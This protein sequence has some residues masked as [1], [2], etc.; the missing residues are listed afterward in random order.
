[1]AAVGN[2]KATQPV[3]VPALG[4]RYKQTRERAEILFGHRNGSYPLPDPRVSLFQT[5]V[6][7]IPS[8]QPGKTPVPEP[9]GSDETRL[10]EA[11]A[12]LKG[13]GGFLTTE[14]GTYLTVGTNRYREGDS[15]P[16][17]VRSGTVEL[18]IVRISGNSATVA[19]NQTEAVL[20]F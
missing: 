3:T 13:G 6:E 18:R 4:P 11:L 1:M 7:A 17:S 10:A 20:R 5:P 14:A 19:L 12:A 16:V 15:L 9:V 8:T 2:S